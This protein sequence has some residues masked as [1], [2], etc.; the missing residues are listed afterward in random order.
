MGLDTSHGCWHGSY[1]SFATWRNY[2]ATEFLGDLGYTVTHA[3]I[4]DSYEFPPERI[5]VQDATDGYPNSVYLGDWESDPLDIIDVLMIH[6]DCEGEIPHRFTGPLA[7]R[8]DGFRQQMTA[9]TD[10]DGYLR[11]ATTRFVNGLLDACAR[12]EA[13]DFH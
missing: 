2:L 1:S 11:A 4:G 7:A 9:E 6:S 10:P 13:V 12:G 5:P 8:L 3:E